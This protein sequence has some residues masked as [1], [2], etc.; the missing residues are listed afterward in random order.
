[1][2]LFLRGTSHHR[3]FVTRLLGLRFATPR[4]SLARDNED[5]DPDKDEYCYDLHERHVPG[6]CRR[7]P[8]WENF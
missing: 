8:F 6:H 7:Q 4:D 2:S 5:D 3:D 1:M